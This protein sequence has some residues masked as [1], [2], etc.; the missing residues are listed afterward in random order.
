MTT[1]L[2]TIGVGQCGLALGLE[3]WNALSAEHG[4]GPDG[5]AKET[6]ERG[7]DNKE[8]FFYQ[9]DNDRYVARGIIADLE[10]RV[11][12]RVIRSEYGVLFNPE[13][14]YR[15]KEGLG[16]GNKWFSGYQQGTKAA[17][18]FIEIVQREAENA[19]ALEGF[20]M[21]HSI[22]GGTGSGFGSYVLESLRDN[23]S[24][25]LVETYSVF[26]SDTKNKK[27]G[28][29][30]DRIEGASS[31]GVVSPYNAVLTLRRLQEFADAVIVVDN[32]SLERLASEMCKE[33]HVYD[34]VNK[35]VGTILTASTAP[36]RYYSSTYNKLSD[37]IAELGVFDMHFIQPGYTPFQLPDMKT[38]VIKTSAQ[39]VI[40]KLLKPSSM[41]V[42]TNPDPKRAKR[43][44]YL[45]SGLAILQGKIS[46]INIDDIILKME[47]RQKFK[48]PSWAGV[49]LGT[50]ICIPPPY[51]KREN[52]VSGLLLAN[53]TNIAD[54]FDHVQRQFETMFSRKVAFHNFKEYPDAESELN[55]CNESIKGLINMYDNATE[56]NFLSQQ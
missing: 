52:K 48:Y 46:D 6:E 38:K 3:W 45:L 44:H 55:I 47:E 30:S 13:N 24:K 50:A 5:F 17:D 8:V 7:V 1:N 26:P 14:I 27:D 41:M 23:F 43:N 4:I 49:R 53:H 42:A 20:I 40:S 51:V 25:K 16:A 19:D 22:S 56:D 18:D 11:I 2:I 32:S 33:L 10:P 21:S 29:N 54:K 15:S 36:I 34:E 31:D 37:H 9:A 39:E 35:M 28:T 12:D